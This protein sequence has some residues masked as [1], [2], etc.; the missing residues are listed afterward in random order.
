M[1][2][3]Y[4]LFTITVYAKD[5]D[6]SSLINNAKF[7]DGKEV[8]YT[9]EVI[10]NVMKRGNYA[11]INVFDGSNAIGIWIPYTESK[12]I[13]T[14]GSYNYKGDT[15]K[16]SGI[17]NRACSEHGGEFDIHSNEIEIMKKG[18]IIFRPVSTGKKY[19][20]IALSLVA[21]LFTWFVFKR[22]F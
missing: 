4:L 18:S 11:W 17:F 12:K 22:K 19:I 7:Y 6:S 20:T 1:V 9:G 2:L 21:S 13:E 10:G 5:I 14:T 8:S 3:F 16:V 15:I